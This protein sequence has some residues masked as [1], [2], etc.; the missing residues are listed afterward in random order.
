MKKKKTAYYWDVKNKKIERIDE[1]VSNKKA[2]RAIRKR[3]NMAKKY[4]DT[5]V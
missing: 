4:V 3:G 1:N 2:K 5:L